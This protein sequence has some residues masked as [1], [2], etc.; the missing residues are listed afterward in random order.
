MGGEKKYCVVIAIKGWLIENP[1][2]IISL[3][4]YIKKWLD[5]WHLGENYAESLF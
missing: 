1:K 4:T 5:P 3:Y 2:N